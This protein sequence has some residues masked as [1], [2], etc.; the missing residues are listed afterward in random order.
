[1]RIIFKDSYSIFQQATDPSRIKKFNLHIRFN[2][3]KVDYLFAHVVVTFS[4]N[5]VCKVNPVN[6]LKVKDKLSVSSLLSNK[7]TG[8]CTVVLRKTMTKQE[9]TLTPPCFPLL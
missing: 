3:K 6:Q 2:E 5:N 4:K 8:L 7:L 1:M 9:N